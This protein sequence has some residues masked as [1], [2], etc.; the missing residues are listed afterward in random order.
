[1]S[2]SAVTFIAKTTLSSSAALIDLDNIPGTATDLLVV[3]SA[4]CDDSAAS[5][6]LEN[7]YIRFNNSTSNLSG[8]VLRNFDGSV[9]SLT[10]TDGFMGDAPNANAT[11]NTFGSIEVYIPNYA[12]LTNKSYSSVSVTESNTS[13]GDDIAMAVTAGL[14]SSTAAITR[15]GFS[16]LADNFVSGSS[17]YC[18][19]ITKA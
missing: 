12:G 4:R 14:W 13:I 1:M 19:G 10:R 18:Y 16:L 9:S 5:L 15:V 7:V 6:G 17:I 3:L 2:N 11:A 8:R